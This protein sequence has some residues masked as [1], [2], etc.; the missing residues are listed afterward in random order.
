MFDTRHD[1]TEL[2]IDLIEGALNEEGY[3]ADRYS[4]RAD[5]RTTAYD[6]IHVEDGAGRKYAVIIE[7][8]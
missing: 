1:E 2:L 4:E 7:E 5:K 6:A 8:E 3:Y